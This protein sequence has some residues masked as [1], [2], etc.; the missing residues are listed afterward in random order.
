MNIQRMNRSS[1]A[2]EVETVKEP[3]S[4]QLQIKL[5][6]KFQ[7]SEAEELNSDDVSNGS[8]DPT[9]DENTT[10]TP[11]ENSA[12]IPSL[13]TYMNRSRLSPVEISRREAPVLDE[14]VQRPLF[15]IF[16][17]LHDSRGNLRDISLNKQSKTFKSKSVFNKKTANKT[18][19]R[20][21]SIQNPTDDDWS[22]FDEEVSNKSP[23]SSVEVSEN[24]GRSASGVTEEDGS[25][26]EE[27]S[28]EI[29]IDQESHVGGELTE[30]KKRQ[31]RITRD[32]RFGSTIYKP[33]TLQASYKLARSKILNTIQNT[34]PELLAPAESNHRYPR[35]TRFPPLDTFRSQR[36]LYN[37]KGDAIGVDS[38]FRLDQEIP[39]SCRWAA[40]I[41]K[42]YTKSYMDSIHESDASDDEE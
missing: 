28:E 24:D 19:H 38:G 15:D 33:E 3:K 10:S 20:K 13:V 17:D 11:F 8:S 2:V 1:K 22:T 29:A 34:T 26:S 36:I 30:A 25:P 12:N 5:K 4:L 42:R 31:T 39:K 23:V 40:A 37:I 35:R 41:R 6:S 32:V 21:V 14:S 9:P 7:L 27:S 16:S 18:S